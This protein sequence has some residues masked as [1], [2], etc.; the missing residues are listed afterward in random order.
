MMIMWK[1]IFT[2]ITLSGLSLL[3]TPLQTQAQKKPTPP[4]KTSQ[5]PTDAHK[6]IV[7]TY[8]IRTFGN[9]LM[10]GFEKK[11]APTKSVK[12]ILAG[13]GYEYGSNIGN[14]REEMDLYSLAAFRAEIQPRYYFS[15]QVFRKLFVAPT[16]GYKYVS[17]HT[18]LWGPIGGGPEKGDHYTG[19][20]VMAGYIV[21]YNRKIGEFGY[22]DAYIGQIVQNAF[23]GY[24]FAG[25]PQDNYKNGIGLHLGLSVGIGF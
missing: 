16:I 15:K 19:Y 6:L 18:N 1:Q 5:T 20:S 4:R 3:F 8:P 13:A 12:L 23:G 7:S 25:A 17:Y 11:Y 22:M 14:A 2:A 24:R 21:G 9:Y 10:M